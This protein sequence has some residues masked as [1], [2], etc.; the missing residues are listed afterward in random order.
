MVDIVA[1]HVLRRRLH[2]DQYVSEDSSPGDL[3]H[4]VPIVAAPA[5]LAIFSVLTFCLMLAFNSAAVA[6]LFPERDI[7][8]SRYDGTLVL[9]LR[10]YM[11]GFFVAFASA[12]RAPWTTRLRYGCSLLLY[13]FLFCLVFDLANLAAFAVS[14][15]HLTLFAAEMVSALTGFLIFALH[16]IG[17]ADMPARSDAPIGQRLRVSSF[18]T[19][20]VIVGVSAALSIWISGFDL[21]LIRDLR[22]VALLGGVS[23]GVFLFVPLVYLLLNL[24]ASIQGISRRQRAYEPPITLVIPA[25][26]EGHAIRACIAAA[27]ASAARYNGRVTVIVVDNASADDTSEQVRTAFGEVDHVRGM[28]LHEA[29]QGKSH[30]LNRGLEAVETEYFARAD[31]DTLLAPNT[32]KGAFKHFADPKVGVVG[33][34]ALPPGKGPF[35][36]ARY[37]EVLLKM[38]YDQVGLG[39][40]DCVVGIAGMLACYNTDAARSVGGFAIG[41][42]GEDTDIALRMGEAGYRLLVDPGVTFISEVPRT[43]HHLRE[44]RTRWFRSIFHVTARNLQYLLPPRIS[45]RGWLVLPYMLMNTVRRAMALPLVI[46]S[47][48]FLILD[49]DPHSTLKAASILALFI[50]TPMVNAIL[51][52]VVNLRFEAFLALPSYIVFRMIRSYLTLESFLSLNFDNYSSGSSRSRR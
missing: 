38:G 19:A 27:D 7:F 47:V 44:Q 5:V 48:N 20:M 9:P 24:L 51:A 4:P 40:A 42:N 15:L 49:P 17:T 30:A 52:I 18:L 8:F 39:A 21:K 32:L 36:G 46:F 41:M 28:L 37:I 3:S 10:L 23:V 45:T 1:G 11:T 29:R 35:D 22:D 43:L 12:I 33:G 13:F 25:H 16:L 26:N 31:A 2:P 6:Q 14:G 50:G 34:L